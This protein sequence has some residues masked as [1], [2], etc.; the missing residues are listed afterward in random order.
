MLTKRHPLREPKGTKNDV[1]ASEE[2][3]G[4]WVSGREPGPGL[5][6]RPWYQGLGKEFPLVTIGWTSV[7]VLRYISRARGNRV[8]VMG[9]DGL[10]RT[11]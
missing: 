7:L 10:S 4:E 1:T 8:D 2:W 9:R 5:G 6:T 11:P 3:R